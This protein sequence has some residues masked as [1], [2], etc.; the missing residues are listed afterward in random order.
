MMNLNPSNKKMVRPPGNPTILKVT[1][2]N[3][4][5]LNSSRLLLHTKMSFLSKKNSRLLVKSSLLFLSP[6]PGRELP[7]LFTIKP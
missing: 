4:V 7:S 1:S 3:K 6:L 5:S 2:P